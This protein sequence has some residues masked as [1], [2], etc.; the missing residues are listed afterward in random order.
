M[1]ACDLHDQAPVFATCVAFLSLYLLSRCIILILVLCLNRGGDHQVI[2]LWNPSKTEPISRFRNGAGYLPQRNLSR[3][4]G[5]EFH[6]V[7]MVL[8]VSSADGNINVSLLERHYE[9]KCLSD[10]VNRCIAVPRIYQDMT[11]S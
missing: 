2:K 10:L 5:M 4:T 8:G 6:P 9:P 11:F 3:L 7:Q 1:F